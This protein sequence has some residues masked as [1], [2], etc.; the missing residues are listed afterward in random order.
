M[1]RR[2]GT[3]YVS[4]D[5]NNNV[6]IGVPGQG[7]SIGKMGPTIYNANGGT[8]PSGG[9]GLNIFGGVN[10]SFTPTTVPVALEF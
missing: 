9:S 10:L 7:V 5:P 2:G 1:G 4:T 3:I 6:P 8:P